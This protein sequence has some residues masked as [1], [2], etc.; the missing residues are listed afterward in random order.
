MEDASRFRFCCC[1]CY[2]CGCCWI[3]N[4]F[5]M[6]RNCPSDPLHQTYFFLVASLA[7]PGDVMTF[8]G[9]FPPFSCSCWQCRHLYLNQADVTSRETNRSSHCVTALKIVFHFGHDTNKSFII[10]FRFMSI[11]YNTHIH[12]SEW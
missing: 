5:I 2:C 3:D 1:R 7:S 8:F 6:W 9:H 4:L 12:W 10:G 11:N